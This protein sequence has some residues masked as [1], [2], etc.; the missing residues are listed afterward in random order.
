MNVVGIVEYDEVGWLGHLR[1]YI[2][3]WCFHYGVISSFVLLIDY[4]IR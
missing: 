4:S 3:V 2:R 1:M